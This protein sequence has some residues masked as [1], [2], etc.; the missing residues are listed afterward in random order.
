M[1]IDL[2]LS[3]LRLLDSFILPPDPVAQRAYRR[4]PFASRH[5]LH[6]TLCGS[7]MCPSTPQQ[8]HAGGSVARSSGLGL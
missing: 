1:N 8:F 2:G 4:K 7:V 6:A 5:L 3:S